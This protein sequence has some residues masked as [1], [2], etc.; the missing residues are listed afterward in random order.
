MK[1]AEVEVDPSQFNSANFSHEKHARSGGTHLSHILQAIQEVQSSSNRPNLGAKQLEAYRTFGFLF[2]RVLF[3]VILQDRMIERPGELEVDGVKIT[4][5][6]V[7]LEEYD[8]LEAKCTWRSMPGSVDDFMHDLHDP[9]RFAHWL[10][11][12]KAQCKALGT[13]R[14]QMWTFWVNGDY[15]QERMPKIRRWAMEFTREEIDSNWA[16]IKKFAKKRGM[17]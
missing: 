13:A 15:R 2:E 14:Q 8:N 12:M 7:D 10:Y 16:M 5:D 3:D 9:E 4:P 17:I 11:Q 1:I 6:A